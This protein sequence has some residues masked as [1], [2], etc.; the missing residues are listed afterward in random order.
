MFLPG[1]LVS[2]VCFDS[3][4]PLKCYE[5]VALPPLYNS[6]NLFNV[7]ILNMLRPTSFRS[8]LSEES[9]CTSSD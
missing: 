5:V 3:I 7:L 9:E 1:S 2:I 6:Y 4:N 8:R